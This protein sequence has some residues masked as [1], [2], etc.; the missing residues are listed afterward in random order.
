MRRTFADDLPRP[1]PNKWHILVLAAFV[2]SFFILGIQTVPHSALRP[3]TSTWNN[4][5][6][7]VILESDRKNVLLDEDVTATLTLTGGPS[8]T[9]V[10]DGGDK[11]AFDIILSDQGRDVIRWSDLYS[12]QATRH[13]VLG[14][15]GTKVIKWVWRPPTEMDGHIL[16]IDGWI[17]RNGVSQ[18]PNGLLLYVGKQAIPILP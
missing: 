3:P 18:R 2:L 9:V 1:H 5:G 12:E 6:L 14:P 16:V 4:E 8:E 17:R 15:M 7:H 11:P 10:L 13:L